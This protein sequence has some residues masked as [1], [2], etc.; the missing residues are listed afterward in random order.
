MFYLKNNRQFICCLLFCFI[1]IVFLSFLEIPCPIR[2][3]F[4]FPCPTCGVSRAWISFI[5]GNI[6]TAFYY[7]PLFLLAPAFLF[8]MFKADKDNIYLFVLLAISFLFFAVYLTRLI[9][10]EIP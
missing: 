10:Y 9:F 7:H 5:C 8:L 6:R 4:T 1:Y 2:R 3:I